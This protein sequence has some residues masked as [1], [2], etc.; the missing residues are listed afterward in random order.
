[1]NQQWIWTELTV[2]GFFSFR[3]AIIF[4]SKIKGI[5]MLKTEKRNTF[6]QFY[7][8]FCIL[9]TGELCTV[10]SSIVILFCLQDNADKM[11]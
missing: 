2:S 1:M 4:F 8:A 3:L 11:V 10:P 5:L 6:S 7:Q 9:P